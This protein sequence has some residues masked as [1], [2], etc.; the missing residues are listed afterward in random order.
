LLGNP[1]FE[2][3]S[4]APW[5]ATTDVINNDANEPAKCCRWCVFPGLAGRGGDRRS[6]D[7]VGVVER[8]PEQTVT[9]RITRAKRSCT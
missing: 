8:Y 6:R 4:A 9:R 5:S 2:T 3:G 1:G 7:I